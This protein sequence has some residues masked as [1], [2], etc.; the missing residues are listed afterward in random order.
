MFTRILPQV[1]HKHAAIER[2]THVKQ[3]K[4]QKKISPAVFMLGGKRNVAGF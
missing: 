2:A 3:K 4:S 1:F